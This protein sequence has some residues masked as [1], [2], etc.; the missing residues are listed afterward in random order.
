MQSQPGSLVLSMTLRVSFGRCRERTVQPS[1]HALFHA[2]AQI[3]HSLRIVVIREPNLKA[4]QS[5][6]PRPRELVNQANSSN[7]IRR[8]NGRTDNT[9]NQI[10][11]I[12]VNLATTNLR[13]QLELK[14]A[15]RG[16]GTIFPL[17]SDVVAEQHHSVN[18]MK[19][20]LL[21]S[22][23]SL[24]L[25]Q[26]A[27]LR[28]VVPDTPELLDRREAADLVR[29]VRVLRG[30]AIT[31]LHDLLPHPPIVPQWQ[32]LLQQF[33]L[34]WVH[35]GGISQSRKIVVEAQETVWCCHDRMCQGIRAHGKP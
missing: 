14:M 33:L 5:S 6:G 21:L 31:G 11:P 24:L 27:R 30:L 32:I 7:H 15:A 13:L 25:Q 19:A 26:L 34:L 16:V 23:H 4:N 12:L 10:V 8:L 29:S 3:I 2:A 22:H 18:H 28:H 1:R 20:I 35:I 17:G 9:Q